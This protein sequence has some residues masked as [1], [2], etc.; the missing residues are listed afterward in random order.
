MNKLKL[1][2]VSGL[3]AL[4]AL[5]PVLMPASGYAQVSEESKKAACEGIGGATAGSEGCGSGAG[6][7]VGNLIKTVVS[8]LSW[9]VGVISVIVLIIGGLKFITA[10]GDS[11]AINSARST[12]IYAL[13]GVVIAA[14]AQVLVV[15]VIGRFTNNSAQPS[16]GSTESQTFC[17]PGTTICAE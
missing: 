7:K 16:G 6:I 2:I 15:F 1:I 10:N 9:V 8:I 3:L 14:L 13:V 12:I 17:Q 11:S 5:A 4:F